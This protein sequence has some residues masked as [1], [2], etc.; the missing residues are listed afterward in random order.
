MSTMFGLFEKQIRHSGVSIRTI[1]NYISTWNKFEK[2]M[3]ELD[4]DLKDADEATQKD[5][6]DYKRYMILS[7]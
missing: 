6:S 5:I 4:P 7:D 3:K 2:W 1:S